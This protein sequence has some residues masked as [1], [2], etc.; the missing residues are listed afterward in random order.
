MR[1]PGV[2]IPLP[3]FSRRL[4]ESSGIPRI[5]RMT[6]RG[7]A[8]N[9]ARHLPILLGFCGLFLFDRTSTAQTEAGL[10]LRSPRPILPTA[11]AE[12]LPR[13]ENKLAIAISFDDAGNVREAHVVQSSGSAAADERVRG[14][15]AARWKARPELMRKGS[16][17]GRQLN[18]KT[19]FIVPMVLFKG[20]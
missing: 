10:I 9:W 5:R 13:K 14:W 7:F 16:Y 8:E 11:I 17:R 19:E 2:R 6:I 3:P 18:S 1:R 15:I 12:G 20:S 4:R